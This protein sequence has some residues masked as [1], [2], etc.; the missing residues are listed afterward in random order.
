MTDKKQ[1]C[2]RCDGSGETH[3]KCH[4]GWTA[5]VC[6]SCRGTGKKPAPKE[7]DRM[8]NDTW[9]K[10][11]ST[12]DC[13]SDCELCMKNYIDTLTNEL[14]LKEELIS[15]SVENYTRL[16]QQVK[17]LEKQKTVYIATAPGRDG[18]M[19]KLHARIKDLEAEIKKKDGEIIHQKQM[20]ICLKSGCVE[21]PYSVFD[22]PNQDCIPCERLIRTDAP[23]PA[24]P[25]KRVCNDC[26]KPMEGKLDH[27]FCTPKTPDD[28][29]PECAGLGLP[30]VFPGAERRRCNTCGVTDKKDRPKDEPQPKHTKER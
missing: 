16:E 14:R 2:P 6:P 26:G 1:K 30:P 19:A 13:D 17:A 28:K 21:F 15:I 12:G 9:C 25:K 3:R 4:D 8:T 18:K 20:I 10:P 23:D 27:L 7:P 24:S 22:G 11:D 29:C 5:I